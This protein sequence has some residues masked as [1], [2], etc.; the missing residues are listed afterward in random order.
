MKQ[1]R[2]QLRYQQPIVLACLVPPRPS[3][4][5]ASPDAQ[6]KFHA[7][8]QR[9]ARGGGSSPP[10]VCIP[11]K[12]ASSFTVQLLPPPGTDTQV[13]YLVLEAGAHTLEG[14][15]RLLAGEE[16]VAIGERSRMPFERLVRNVWEEGPEMLYDRT[17][18]ALQ[19]LLY[20][21]ED[22]RR[23]CQE[24]T[25]TT[26]ATQG[27]HFGGQMGIKPETGSI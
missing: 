3:S 1:V 8:R 20:I 13:A 2:L 24:R 12:G 15:A 22:T 5:L 19:R 27:C 23:F 16:T 17:K 10:L 9:S 4:A 18:T 26:N 6:R 14:G 21:L 11:F 7:E 25:R